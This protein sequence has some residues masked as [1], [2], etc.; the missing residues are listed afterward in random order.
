MNLEY[1]KLLSKFSFNYKLR[2][3]SK[4][5]NFTLQWWWVAT[6]EG[7]SKETKETDQEMKKQ[8]KSRTNNVVGRCTLTLL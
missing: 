1:D 4:E 6:E 8:G 2:H 7:V 3:Y 5:H